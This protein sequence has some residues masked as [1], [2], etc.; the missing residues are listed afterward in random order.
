M[1]RAEASPISYRPYLFKILLMLSTIH[2]II[3]YI[4]YLKFM[5]LCVTVDLCRNLEYLI[6]RAFEAIHCD[7]VGL[8]IAFIAVV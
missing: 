7:S 4:G 8:L 2:I 3:L 6:S 5:T 1:G